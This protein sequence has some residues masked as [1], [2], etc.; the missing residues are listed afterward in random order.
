M[1]TNLNLKHGADG[2]LYYEASDGHWYPYSSLPSSGPSYAANQQYSQDPS[3]LQDSLY[4]GEA[5]YNDYEA[6]AGSF[7]GDP[8]IDNDDPR[9]ASSSS[10]KQ[11]E[12]D[13]NEFVKDQKKHKRY[14][15]EPNDSSRR[16]R[17]KHKESTKKSLDQMMKPFKP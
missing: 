1:S 4:H 10:R 16:R 14:Q 17:H 5:Q 15:V 11:A 3:P 7:Q 8:R 6:E 9:K 2:Q 13:T 12:E